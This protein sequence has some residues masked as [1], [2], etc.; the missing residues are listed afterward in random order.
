M[1]LK[2]IV[3]C[4]YVSELLLTVKHFYHWK[5]S[6][7]IF[8][9]QVASSIDALSEVALLYNAYGDYGEAKKSI[10]DAYLAVGHQGYVSIYWFYYP[11]SNLVDTTNCMS[12]SDP[13]REICTRITSGT[14]HGNAKFSQ[15]RSILS[16][17]TQDQESLKQLMNWKNTGQS[18]QINWI[19]LSTYIFL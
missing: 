10:D 19:Y 2:T 6:V 4:I 15:F 18:N 3:M 8:F 12:F 16:K 13:K 17:S 1:N 5:V 11:S 14:V 7:W 9:V